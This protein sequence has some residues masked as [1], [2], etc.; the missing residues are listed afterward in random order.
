MFTSMKT[1]NELHIECYKVICLSNLYSIRHTVC[2]PEL[3][4]DFVIEQGIKA[5]YL[6]F[7]SVDTVLIGDAFAKYK[8]RNVY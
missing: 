7:A 3:T 4:N 6:N 1:F 5:L 8:V 2:V